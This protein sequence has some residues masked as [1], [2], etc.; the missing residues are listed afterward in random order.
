MSN[1]QQLQE[2]HWVILRLECN[3]INSNLN[4]N[5]ILAQC[6]TLLNNYW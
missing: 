2:T 4:Y 3:K 5:N 6:K 1:T